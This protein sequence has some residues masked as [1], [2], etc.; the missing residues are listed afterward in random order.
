MI[1]QAVLAEAMA[2]YLKL[3]IGRPI[4]K[5]CGDLNPFGFLPFGKQKPISHRNN[6]KMMSPL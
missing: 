6:I 5:T 2:S 3:K 4:L 1:C